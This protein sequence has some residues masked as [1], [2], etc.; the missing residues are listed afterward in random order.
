MQPNQTGPQA[1]QHARIRALITRTAQRYGVDPH[2]ALTFA[3]LESRF[4]PA[5]KGDLDWSARKGG[6]L[7]RTVVR[8]APRFADNPA[9]ILPKAWHSYG[10]FQLLAPYHVQP[11]EHPSVLAN[12]IVNASRGVLYLRKL[13]EQTH[14]DVDQARLLYTGAANLAPD[15]KGP[16]LDKLHAAQREVTL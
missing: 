5:A 8:D 7:Y 2:T 6:E 16:I 12:P 3:W 13:L 9:R 4:D 11:T 10:L 14:G 1:P 15:V